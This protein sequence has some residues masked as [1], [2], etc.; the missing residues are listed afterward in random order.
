MIPI[1]YLD[2]KNK[3]Y[4]ITIRINNWIWGHKI[5]AENNRKIVAFYYICLGENLTKDIQALHIK[6]TKH[7]DKKLNKT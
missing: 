4:K 6:T 5:Q 2:F 1:W 7:C 3:I